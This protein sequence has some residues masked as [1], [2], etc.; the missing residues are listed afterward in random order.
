MTPHASTVRSL[1]PQVAWESLRK[2]L[3]DFLVRLNQ[4]KPAQAARQTEIKHELDYVT[5]LD[6]WL[7]ERI[8]SWLRDTNADWPII[9]EEHVQSAVIPDGLSWL[10]D[11]LDGTFNLVHHIGFHSISVALMLDGV[12]SLGVVFDTARQT[13]FSAVRGQGAWLGEKR[14]TPVA[15]PQ[16][17]IAVSSGFV[18]WALARDARILEQLRRIGKLRILGSQGLQLA[19]VGCGYLSANLS[20]EAKPWDDAAGCLIAQEAGC[21]YGDFAGAPV[22]P[23]DGARTVHDTTLISAAALPTCWPQI[24]EILYPFVKEQ[25]A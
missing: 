3:S 6:R 12:P 19:Y 24:Q 2:D 17:V 22:F 8:E 15:L 23:L 1:P 11:P 5:T 9:A 7:Q 20:V 18:D 16:D 25:T 13:C 14:L 4:E 10:I 21:Y